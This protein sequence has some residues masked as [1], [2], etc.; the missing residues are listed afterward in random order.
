MLKGIT[1]TGG[2]VPLVSG[3]TIT[4][5]F[6]DSSNFLGSDGNSGLY[7]TSYHANGN[8]VTFNPE[9][10]YAGFA[11]PDD[12]PGFVKEY[13]AYFSLLPQSRT[14][15]ITDDEM[16]LNCGNGRSLSFS[17]IGDSP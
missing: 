10:T 5:R 2:G 8:I 17:R 3:R 9:I 6:V 12:S 11:V 14:F 16:L 4:L 7:G 13:D 1:D 15:K